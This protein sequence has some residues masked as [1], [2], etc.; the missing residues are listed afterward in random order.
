VEIVL[1]TFGRIFY[2]D[3]TTLPKQNDKGQPIELAYDLASA[4]NRS[5]ATSTPDE[6]AELAAAQPADASLN[7]LGYD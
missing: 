6:S 5:I 7:N 4:R 2:T 3:D 1:P